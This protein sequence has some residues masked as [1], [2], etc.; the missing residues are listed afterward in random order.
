MHP[1][2]AKALFDADVATLSPALA[3]RRAWT[4]HSLEFPLVDCSFTATNRTPLRL[5]LTCDDWN[6]LPPEISLHNADGTLLITP[7]QNPTS[8]FHPS[9]HPVTNRLFI[10]MKG[11]RE[12][13]THPSHVSDPWENLRGH[14]SYS[15]GGIITQIWNGWLKGA[16]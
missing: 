14:S 16:G 12:Y 4:I 9:P 7:L 13:H 10:C 6:E 11:T 8:I 5:K 1:A 3:K 15:I 2:A